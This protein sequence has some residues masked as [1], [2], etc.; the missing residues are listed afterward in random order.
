MNRMLVILMVLFLAGCNST[1]KKCDV[2][3]IE[4][5]KTVIVVPPV[6]MTTV[7]SKPTLGVDVDEATQADVARYIA[8]LDSYSDDLREIIAN[9]AEFLV[10]AQ[11]EADKKN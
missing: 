3:V 4:T 1:P 11:K 10:N 7:P 5:T 8:N 6:E 2:P 9:I